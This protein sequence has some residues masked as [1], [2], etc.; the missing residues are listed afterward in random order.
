[1][2]STQASPTLGRPHFAPLLG[3]A[4]AA[5]RTS[6][7]RRGAGR[8]AIAHGVITRGFG[9][10]LSLCPAMIITESQIDDLFDRIERAV[11]DTADYVVQKARG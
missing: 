1:M 3:A 9:D 2:P 4:A 7:H 11:A 8:R 10:V 6:D 5:G